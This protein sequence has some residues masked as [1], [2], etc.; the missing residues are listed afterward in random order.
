MQHILKNKAVKR[1]RYM[2]GEEER[3]VITTYSKIKFT[4]II[5]MMITTTAAVI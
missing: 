1:I 2:V 4:S 5:V 3:V